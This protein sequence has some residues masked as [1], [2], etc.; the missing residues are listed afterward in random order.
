MLDL[1]TEIFGDGA[2]TIN[3]A[4]CRPDQKRQHTK[5]SNFEV[6]LPGDG[7]L[8]LEDPKR[9]VR[10]G[11]IIGR[12]GDVIDHPHTPFQISE[13]RQYLIEFKDNGPGT[14]SETPKVGNAD[15]RSI[16]H[17]LTDEVRRFLVKEKEE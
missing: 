1:T 13:S 16:K 4:C 14:Q 8:I 9:P 11:W 3:L 15:A 6:F 7:V 5:Q 12:A 2:L 10:F 17:W